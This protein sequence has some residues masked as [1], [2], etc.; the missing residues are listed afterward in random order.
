MISHFYLL[1]TS[2]KNRI[3]ELFKKPGK[4]ILYLFLILLIIAGL[5]G[6]VFGSIQNEQS[7][8]LLY[9][10]PI[11]FG[12]LLIFY[13]VSIQKGLS[14]GDS[15]F[16]MNDVNLLFVSPV[17]PRATLL[18]G[19]IK[20]IGMSFWAGFFI[21]FQST[22]LSYFGIKYNGVLILFSVFI[23][24]MVVLTLLSLVIYNA[25]NGNSSRK[26]FVRIFA[27]VILIPLIIFFGLQYFQTKD[28][29]SALEVVVKSHVLAAVPFI[30]WASAGAVALIEGEL[31]A[32]F[33]WLGLLV[34]S[35]AGL[36]IYIMYS[37][38]DYYEDVLVATETAFEKKRAAAEGDLQSVASTNTKVKVKQTGLKGIGAR[39]FFYKHM[40]ETFRQNR[41]GFLS[42][43]MFIT[44]IIMIIVSFFLRNKIDVILFLQILMWMQIF[45]IGTGRGLLETYSHYIYM[46]PK[47]SFVKLIWSNMELMLR[48]L[49]DS[50]ILLAIPGF[51]S[52][53]HPLHILGSVLVYVGF[54]FLL[55]GINYVF[56]LW[57]ETNL[58]KGLLIAVY[59]LAVILFILPGLAA[60]IIIGVTIEGLAGGT[61]GLLV[62]TVWE[63][64]AGIIC[65]ALS[66][67]ILRNCDIPSVKN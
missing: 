29:L 10:T 41:F 62:L 16:E 38:S 32:G 65:F 31:L 19:L 40:R 61:I 64:I 23:L 46:I 33:G 54:S 47:S 55:L 42:L 39:V 49:I 52:G 2:L 57:L 36:F 53:S 44:A 56:L 59:I 35:G 60:A 3:K 58:S 34:I 18:Y 66:R 37:R 13:I 4:F 6:A 22:S 48:E 27:F 24:N 8:P 7:I 1:R 21:L 12:F 67:N 17:N 30:G 15:I 9:F 20:L 63:L 45:L 25:T 11:F 50:L 26:L 43:H 28:L 5:I 14:S 51:V